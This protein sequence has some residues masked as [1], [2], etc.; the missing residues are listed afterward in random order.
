M[1]LVRWSPLQDLFDF[2]R[3]MDDFVRR[4]FGSSFAPPTPSLGLARGMWSPAVDTFTRDGDLVIRAELPG[5]DPERDVDISVQN[6]MRRLRGERRHEERGNGNGYQRLE[7]AHGAF[8]RHF[9]LPE[10][11]DTEGISA[12]YENGILEVVVPGVADVTAGRKI[13]VQV[14]QGRK[15]ISAEGGKTES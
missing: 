13:S 4:F 5:I 9:A 7:S 6:G 1:Q 12:T 2:R 15:A 14:G 10:G 8:E 11:V 3:D